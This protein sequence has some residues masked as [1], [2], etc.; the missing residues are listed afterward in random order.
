MRPASH[1][2]PWVLACVGLVLL[3]IGVLTASALIP[4]ENAP[5][6]AIEEAAPTKSDGCTS[7]QDEPLSPEEALRVSSLG[8]KN[9]S[10]RLAALDLYSASPDARSDSRMLSDLILT[11]E[12][13]AVRRKAFAVAL[14]LARTEGGKEEIDVL[15]R[16]VANPHSDVRRDSVRAC[17]D[18]PRYELLEELLQLASQ[19]GPERP[20]A[21]EALAFM[22]DPQAQ[23][24]VLDTAR[25]E[26]VSRAD[27]IQAIAL[28]ARTDLEE[29]VEYLNELANGEDEELR[30]FAIEALATNAKAEHAR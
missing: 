21:I 5:V 4:A 26:R 13:A 28:L 24:T 2:K 6:I 22:D 8:A 20:V 10:D 29:G 11:D 1:V 23:Q 27:R 18:R 16:G 15:K 9:E 14:D 12:S 17:R 30:A 3:A 25:S 19:E 7:P